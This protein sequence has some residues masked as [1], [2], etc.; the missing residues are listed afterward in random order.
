MNSL[1]KVAALTGLAAT[2]NAQA[3]NW[4]LESPTALPGARERTATGTD[5][6]LYYMYGGQTGAAFAGNDE[7]WSYDG[8]TWTML[9]ASGASAGTRTGAVGTFDILRGKFVVFGG[10]NT[11]GV[12]GNHDNDTWEWDATN[13][14]VNVTPATGSPDPRW[15]VNNSVY[16]PGLGMVFHGGAAWDATGASYQSTETWAWTG[17]AWALLSSSGPASQNAMMEYRSIQG[18][19]ILHGGQNM[20]GETWR[21]DFGTGTWTQLVTGGTTPFNSS[22]PTQGLFAAMSYYN[23]LTGMM[24]VHGGNGGSSSNTTWQFDGTD[25][26]DI[27]SNGVGCRNGGMHWVDALNKGVY[28]PCNEANGTRNRTR[29]HGPQTWGSFTMMGSDCPVVSSGLTA[30]MS[31]PAMP[32][33]GTNLDINLTNLTPGNLP[34][35]LVGTAA[36]PPLSLNTLF[37]GSGPNCSLQM[38]PIVIDV[39]PT[40]SLAVPNNPIFVGQVL[41]AQGVQLEGTVLSAAN[42]QYAVITLGEL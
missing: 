14:W 16:I 18:D 40:F 38:S 32:A 26:T 9:T 8:T 11:N 1:L 30:G 4:T 2:A 36:I 29:T 24:I 10:H 25:W 7:L 13:G 31:S 37:A 3:F 39:T 41:Y 20:L 12:S 17:T 33:I 21:F 27:S 15:L 23:P 34:L 42:T 35:M 28:G 5:G 6:T 22:N 19:L